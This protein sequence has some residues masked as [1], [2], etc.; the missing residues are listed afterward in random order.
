MF[1]ITARIKSEIILRKLNF[2]FSTFSLDN[3]LVHVGKAKGREIIATPWALP[4]ALF[5]LWISHEEE[6]KE[7]I[8]YRNDVSEIHQIHIQLHEIAHFLFGHPTLKFNQEMVLDIINGKAVLVEDLV[9]MRSS[10]KALAE[11][12]AETLAHLI[13]QRVIQQASMGQLLHDRISPAEKLASFFEVMG[14]L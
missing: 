11:T 4:G 5:G 3:F 10:K 2:D 6:A 1:D 8:F 14:Q 9:Q 13:Q 12:E 7:Y